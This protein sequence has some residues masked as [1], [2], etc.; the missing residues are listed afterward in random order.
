MI[1]TN[2]LQQSI[3]FMKRFTTVGGL[4]NENEDNSFLLSNECETWKI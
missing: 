1:S 4:F 3:N 2:T